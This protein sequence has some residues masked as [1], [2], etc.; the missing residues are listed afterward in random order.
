MRSLMRSMYAQVIVSW[1][2]PD[3]PCAAANR[4]KASEKRWSAAAG[5]PSRRRSQAAR[6]WSGRRRGV[7]EIDL[8]DAELAAIRAAL[9]FRANDRELTP[10]DIVV[11][12]EARGIVLDAEQAWLDGDG[13]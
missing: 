4:F 9:G 11:A 1:Y 3:L 5:G 2:R 7:S 10:A 13:P 12:I 6:M 8:I